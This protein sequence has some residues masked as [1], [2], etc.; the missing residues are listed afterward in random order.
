MHIHNNKDGAVTTNDFEIT[1]TAVTQGGTPVSGAL[2]PGF[3]S[4]SNGIE[5][6]PGTYTFTVLPF[7]A[8]A[9]KLFG[10]PTAPGDQVEVKFKLD[11]AN[12]A[13]DK[14]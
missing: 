1:D 10:V 4:S 13:P 2:A 6:I 5:L 14:T 7:D 12:V 3:G 9:N 11:V 8:A